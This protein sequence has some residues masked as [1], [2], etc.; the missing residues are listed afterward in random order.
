MTKT[1][2]PPATSSAGHQTREQVEA[3]WTVKHAEFFW[4]LQAMVDKGIQ[5]S[6]A[7]PVAAQLLADGKRK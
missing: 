4:L 6:V 2:V 7:A 3:G 5:S 1:S